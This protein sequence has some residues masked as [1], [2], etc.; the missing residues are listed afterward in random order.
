MYLMWSLFIFF[1]K[2][3]QLHNR[4]KQIQYM[5]SS[6]KVMPF[7]GL[8]KKTKAIFLWIGLVLSI[9]TLN[10]VAFNTIQILITIQVFKNLSTNTYAIWTFF[11]LFWIDLLT[12]TN[13]M[14]FLVLFKKMA[15]RSSKEKN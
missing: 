6:G 12:L 14:C 13:G 1:V 2:R 7:V 8:S 4:E 9:N 15:S 10:Y 3:K 5:Q 11:C